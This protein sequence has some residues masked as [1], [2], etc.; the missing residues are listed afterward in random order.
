MIPTHPPIHPCWKKKKK[1]PLFSHWIYNDQHRFSFLWKAYIF[2]DVY[3][4]QKF[5]VKIHMLVTKNFQTWFQTVAKTVCA[6]M[7]KRNSG[8]KIT[9]SV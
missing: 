5:Q 1:N 3:F 7:Q 4:I 6:C 9:S 2:S 8:Y